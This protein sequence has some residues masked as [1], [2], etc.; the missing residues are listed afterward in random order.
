MSEFGD[1]QER[2]GAALRRIDTALSERRAP[3]DNTSMLDALKEKLEEE[4]VL[5]SQLQERIRALH[6]KENQLVADHASEVAALRQELDQAREA[7]EGAEAMRSEI[8]AIL[9]DLKPQ[10]EEQSHA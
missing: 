2:L 8:E 1:L 6:D 5:T 3:V 9:A 4:R 7:A 10:L